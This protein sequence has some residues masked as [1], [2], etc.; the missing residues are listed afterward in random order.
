MCKRPCA[1]VGRILG[2]RTE[3]CIPVL[4]LPGPSQTAFSQPQ[5]SRVWN[6]GCSVFVYF[7]KMTLNALTSF[8]FLTEYFKDFYCM[9]IFICILP[10]DYDPLEVRNYVSFLHSRAL[11]TLSWN[12]GGSHSLLN[13]W[14]DYRMKKYIRNRNIYS[15]SLKDTLLIICCCL[16]FP[17]SWL[18]DLD[19]IQVVIW[20]VIPG[21][22]ESAK[23]RRGG[24]KLQACY[25]DT[26]RCG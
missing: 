13:E 4:A 1:V 12:I 21:N 3:T 24:K 11:L 7:F 26:Y 8:V 14:V 6:E 23:A 19:R 22:T 20:N 16:D 9:F 2:S 15:L 25:Q 10:L 17:K 18:W 5:L